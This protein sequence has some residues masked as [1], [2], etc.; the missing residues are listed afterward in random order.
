MFKA[1][2]NMAANNQS[3]NRVV[4]VDDKSDR[5][6]AVQCVFGFLD[7]ESVVIELDEWRS[8]VNR[9][10]GSCVL[11]IGDCGGDEALLSLL[12][13]VEE[14]DARMP[15]LVLSDKEDSTAVPELAT[16]LLVRTINYPFDH[17][18][19]Q[20]ILRGGLRL[21]AASHPGSTRAPRYQGLVGASRGMQRLRRAMEQVAQTDSTVMILGETGTGK[22]VVAKNIHMASLRRDKPFVAVN[23]GA[24]P[25]DLLESELFG[26]EKGAFT[27]AITARQGRFEM[28][29]GGTLFL[30]EIGDMPLAMQV[31]LLRVLQ[32]RAFER[33]GSN[34][35]IK[36]DVRIITATHRDM[37]NAVRD[38]RFREDLY[39]RLNVFPVELPPLRER[40]EDVPLLI[41]EM[42]ARLERSQQITV[43]LTQESVQAL[44]AYDWP[45][46]VRELAN[47]VERLAILFPSMLVDSHQLPE[48]YL[49]EHG[50]TGLQEVMD[51]LETAS[52][53]PADRSEHLPHEGLDLKEHLASLETRFITEALDESNGVVTKA[54]K[55]LRM[56]RTT[57]VEKLRKYGIDSRE[58]R[59]SQ[60]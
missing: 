59:V 14:Y 23:C 19:L 56:R 29:R 53:P 39:Y 40:R 58:S 26:H 25:G 44:S 1:Y 45:G 49:P 3:V 34:R 24:I 37:E 38:G 2:A 51:N 54:A 4:I 18:E 57:L 60:I 16:K 21:P 52:P 22:E 20:N 6:H 32:E 12:R 15:V 42:I 28:A 17:K 46:N 41:K 55:L 47:L 48:K 31:K 13:Q 8:A 35:S 9:E 30:D 11:V 7:C 5:A 33:V 36:A 50:K 43:R 10:E 27:G